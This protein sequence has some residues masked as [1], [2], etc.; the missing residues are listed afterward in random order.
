VAVIARTILTGATAALLLFGAAACSSNDSAST[1]PQFTTTTLA[2]G[3]PLRPL[4]QQVVKLTLASAAAQG[5]V[6][7]QACLDRVVGQLSD[8][9]AQLIVAATPKADTPTLTPA[10][11]AAAQAAATCLVPAATTTSIASG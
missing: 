3:T 4:Q 1:V 11:A 8:A 5:A 2:A 7:D 10:G 6:L 9:D